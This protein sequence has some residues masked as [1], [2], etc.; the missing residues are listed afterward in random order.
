[1]SDKLEPMIETERNEASDRME[2]NESVNDTHQLEAEYVAE[3]EDSGMN[4]GS[5]YDGS[6]FRQQIENSS[7]Q[8]SAGAAE[9]R[10]QAEKEKARFERRQA[11]ARKKAEKKA[12]KKAAGKAKGHGIIFRTTGFVIA[13]AAF[14]V[15][16]LGTMYFVGDGLGIINKNSSQAQT[17]TSTQVGAAGKDVLNKDK[18]NETSAINT[19]KTDSSQQGLVAVDVSPIVEEVMPSIVSITSKTIVQ[20]GMN[21]WFYNYYF[22][23]QNGNSYEQ[24]GAGSGIIIG[25]NDTELLVITNNHVV[26]GADSL[27]VQFIDGSSVDAVIKGTEA[28]KDLAVVAIKLSDIDSET[29]DKIKVATL[30]DSDSMKVGEGTI[31]I[32]NALGYGQSVTVGVISALDREVTV[33]DRTMNMIQTDAAINRGN[34]GGALLNMR[35][36]VIGINAAKYSSDTV[37]GM[38]FAIPVSSVSDIIE[39]LMNRETLTKVDTADRGYLN[40]RGRDVTDE[41]ANDFNAP[42]GVLIREVMEGGA[43]D[44][45][46]LEKSQIITKINDDE[47][48]SMDELKERLEYYEKGATVTLTIE[49]LENKSYKEK[50]VK[51]VLGGQME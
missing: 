11:K 7:H 23:G 40:I 25:Q 16:A 9:T 51:V 37:E 2:T 50:E 22:G 19:N 18:E 43:A 42:K 30:G 14:G 47:V 41:L 49:Y 32:G 36:E 45:A 39:K 5:V 15:I 8:E 1:M 12:A 27:Q 28:N 13:A 34:S 4:R 31:A 6:E 38:G 10:R 35:G 29:K 20:S 33:E 48:K 3:Q 46:G 24:T 44:K 21:D 26:E 17:I